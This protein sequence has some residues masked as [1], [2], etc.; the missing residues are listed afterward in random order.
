MLYEG[1][2]FL[3]QVFDAY[4]DASL[5]SFCL[6]YA[7]PCFDL[8]HPRSTR[9]CEVDVETFMSL[10]PLLYLFVFVS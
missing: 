1:F 7:E 3:N 2:D 6:K 8:V 4:E 5:D 10:E 9:R